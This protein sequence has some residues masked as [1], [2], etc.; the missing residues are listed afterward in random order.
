MRYGIICFFVLLFISAAQPQTY[1]I[2]DYKQQFIFTQSQIVFISQDSYGFI[3]VGTANGAFRYDGEEWLNFSIKNGLPD[4]QVIS[5]VEDDS[6]RLWI[7]TGFG[8]ACLDI[9]NYYNPRFIN[10]ELCRSF[11]HQ[12][13]TMYFWKNTLWIGTALEGLYRLKNGKI[14]PSEPDSPFNA[15]V[16]IFGIGEINK[17]NLGIVIPDSGVYIVDSDFKI[18][19]KINDFDGDIPV[20][21]S[22]NNQ[23]QPVLVGGVENLYWLDLE[24][25]RGEPLLPV[26]ITGKKTYFYDIH[27]DASK[28][29]WAATDRGVITWSPGRAE[30]ISESNGLPSRFIREVFI[31]R[32][33]NV[34]IGSYSSGLFKLS[35][36]EAIAYGKD[37][38]LESGVV[39]TI[40][41]ETGNRK[42][43]GTDAGI[44]KIENDRLSRDER[45]RRLDEL[46]IWKIFKD[47]DNNIWIGGEN[48]LCLFKNN[49]LYTNPY[50]RISKNMITFDIF[51]STSGIYW[52]GT[53]DGLFKLQNNHLELIQEINGIPVKN[54]SV[55]EEISDGSL[56]FGTNYGIIHHTGEKDIYYTPEN[57][58]P[59]RLINDVYQ[60]GDGTVWMGSDYG[61]VKKTNNHFELFGEEIGLNGI[62]ITQILEDSKGVLWLCT[63]NGLHKFENNKISA[64]ITQKDGLVGDEFVTHSSSLIDSDGRFWLGLFGGLS[65]INP[66]RTLKAP[67]APPKILLKKAQAYKSQNQIHSFMDYE[68]PSI[69]FGLKNIIFDFTG[70]YFHTEQDLSFRYRLAGLENEWSDINRAGE[71]RYHNLW[72]GRYKLEVLGIL[73]GKICGNKLE[74]E[75]VIDR[76][77]WLEIWFILIVTTLI[78]ALVYL[79]INFQQ[80]RIKRQKLVLE[81]KIQNRTKELA[82]TKAQLESIIDHA[83]SAIVTVNLK[84][85]INTW[86]K[87]AETMFGYSL[88]E[89]ANRSISRIDLENDIY[90]FSEILAEVDKSGELNQLELKKLTRE[91]K[92]IDLMITCTHLKNDEVYTLVMDDFTERNQ[93][94]QSVL[95]REKLLGA[96]GALNKL[97]ATLSHYINN[98]LM[99][100]SGMAQLSRLDRSYMTKLIETS[101]SQTVRIKAVMHSLADLVQSLNLK[102]KNYVGDEY[103]LYDIEKEIQ[104]YTE[105]ISKK[106]NTP[107]IPPGNKMD[108]NDI[109]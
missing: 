63:E 48:F 62:S 102:T 58:L 14:I 109:Y 54:V 27:Y 68:V 55:I 74:K 67:A 49:K 30:I 76:P 59:A 71:V 84:G 1:P 46:V 12:I 95:N 25:G 85:K 3:W 26:S 94:M 65:V 33:N 90:P 108:S 43:I 64:V 79:A 7:G 45:F 39:N 8:L 82:I 86:N 61:L 35:K 9:S 32:E 80:K 77:F 106:S 17:N 69:P 99:A 89:M 23:D 57:G 105:M 53:T 66:E 18:L 97:L 73:N 4:N 41:N 29:A 40:I 28:T 104:A 83:G 47:H 21:L 13:H 10:T 78:F 101:E 31:D 107:F 75:F 42:L 6:L 70:L 98:A 56:Y 100:I 51:Q 19:R 34:W 37:N 22:T 16:T 36:R 103:Q 15:P 11:K 44:F 24:K 81:R 20:S 96:I 2:V 88:A 60:A 5:I 50:P 87:K 92:E 72:P 38:G 91:N 52:F 93:L